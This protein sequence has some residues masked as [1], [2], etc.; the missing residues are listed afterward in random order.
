FE[1]FVVMEWRQNVS[2]IAFLIPNPC[3]PEPF[4]K[5]RTGLSKDSIHYAQKRDTRIDVIFLDQT[6]IMTN[7]F[8][9]FNVNN[10]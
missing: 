10:R 8:Y 5:L 9:Y 6:Q 3:H 2:R 7:S 4:N 1:C